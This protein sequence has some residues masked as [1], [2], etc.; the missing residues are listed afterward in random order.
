[1]K[2]QNINIKQVYIYT[3]TVIKIEE[4][5]QLRQFC[6]NTVNLFS[7]NLNELSCHV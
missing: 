4:K 3:N 5:V 1:M 2:G 7:R 6:A